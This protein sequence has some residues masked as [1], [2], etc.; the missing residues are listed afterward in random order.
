M[1]GKISR[2]GLLFW[3]LSETNIASIMKPLITLTLALSLSVSGGVA[4]RAQAADPGRK[5][6]II[7][8]LADDLGYGDL[9]SFGQAIIKTPTL[10]RLA[11]QGMRF[12]QHYSGSPVCAPARCV[13][14]TGKHP[15][16]AFVRDNHEIGTWYSFEGQIPIPAAEPCVAAAL[17]SAGYATAAFGKWG[18]GGVGSSGDPLKHGFDHFFG[19]NDQRHA[20]NYYPQFLI[21]DEGRLDLAGNTNVSVKEGLS[22]APGADP[23]DSASY[24]QF[25]GKEYAPDLCHQRALQ[26]IRDNKDRPFFL[27][28]PTTVP[29]LALQ[30]PEDSLDEYKGKL[31]DKPYVGGNGYLPQQYPHAAYAAMVTRLDRDIG[32]MVQLVQDL[33]LEEETIFI[34]T[35]DNGAVYPLSG[36]DPVFFKSNGALR[37][38]KGGIYE[39]GIREPLIVRWKGHVPPGTVSDFV[40]GF[41]DWFPTL[42]DL[43]GATNARLKGLDGV[44][45]MPTLLGRKQAP[46]PFLYREFHGYGGQQAVRVG[47]WKLIHRNLLARKNQPAS[48]TT[49]LYNLAA[50][51]SEEHNVA[52]GHPAVVARLQKIM[53]QQHTVSPQFPFQETLDKTVLEQEIH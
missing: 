27:Y 38:Y 9:G 10:D 51:P 52:T 50:D 34:F 7:F 29:H 11:A 3:K 37:G 15:G 28:Y 41:E 25:I 17:Q 30:V 12:T 47:D 16:H 45:L 49:E 20:H 18:L 19:F 23:N 40:S 42:L 39:G 22:I 4:G 35:S 53:D 33:G 48:P 43:A 32:K 6:N 44:S 31:E 5:P 2:A 21:D 24:A 46:R 14:M 36:Y 26:F 8:I 1:T 13:L